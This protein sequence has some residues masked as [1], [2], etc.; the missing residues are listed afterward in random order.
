MINIL[1]S[2][3]I[4]NDPRIYLYL[5]NYITPKTKVLIVPWSFEKNESYETYKLN[6]S[7]IEELF[8]KFMPYQISRDNFEV[9]DYYED[10]YDTLLE[11]IKKQDLLYFPGGSPELLYDRM[12]EKGIT[13]AIRQ[14]AKLVIGSSA[15]ALVQFKQYHLTPYGKDKNISFHNGLGLL[16]NFRIEVHYEDNKK[17]NKDLNTVIQMAPVDI[18]TIKDDE[19][20][21]IDNGQKINL[22]G[23]G[24]FNKIISK[25]K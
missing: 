25:K 16:D 22:F 12:R 1:L 14:H 5:K 17:K 7:Y 21:I 20:I 4:I 2:R 19:M 24:K 9:L 13:D 10:K 3:G 15:G 23:A 8:K 18:Y 6:G 11:K